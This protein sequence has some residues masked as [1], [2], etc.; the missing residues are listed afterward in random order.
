MSFDPTDTVDDS[1]ITPWSELEG[2]EIAK[3]IK[4]AKDQGDEKTAN[5]LR[6]I[7]LRVRVLTGDKL[8]K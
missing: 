1:R 4:K 6:V 3:E 5:T 8:P 7:D 2:K